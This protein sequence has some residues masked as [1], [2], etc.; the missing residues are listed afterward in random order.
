MTLAS[1]EVP[2]GFILEKNR[3]DSLPLDDFFL[4]KQ[5][6]ENSKKSLEKADYLG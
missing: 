2:D 5:I 6:S 1:A 4:G 3:Y